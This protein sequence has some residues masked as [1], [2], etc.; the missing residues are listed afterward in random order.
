[1]NFKLDCISALLAASSTDPMAPDASDRFSGRHFPQLLKSR[2]LSRNV[3]FVLRR[4]EERRADT[5][6]DDATLIQVFVQHPVLRFITASDI[7]FT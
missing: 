2:L 1:M 7:L 6:V 4:D 5:N 3:K